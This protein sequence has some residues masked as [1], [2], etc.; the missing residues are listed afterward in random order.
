[1]IHCAYLNLLLSL[2]RIANVLTETERHE[3]EISKLAEFVQ[4][5]SGKKMF[6]TDVSHH[7]VLHKVLA[8]GWRPGSRSYPG[9]ARPKMTSLIFCFEVSWYFEAEGLVHYNICAIVKACWNRRSIKADRQRSRRSADLRP[10]STTIR[11]RLQPASVAVNE[12]RG[13]KA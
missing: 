4:R 5:L 12:E 11:T 6:K 8:N 7:D 13:F 10:R 9:S 2:G 3:A 1:M